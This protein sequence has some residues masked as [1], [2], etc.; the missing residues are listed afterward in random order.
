MVKVEAF[1]FFT[2]TNDHLSHILSV[3]LYIFL[4]QQKNQAQTYS[5]VTLKHLAFSR[6]CFQNCVLHQPVPPDKGYFGFKEKLWRNL[7]PYVQLI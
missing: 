3:K 1:F 4:E 5:L 6:N 7:K 2:Q